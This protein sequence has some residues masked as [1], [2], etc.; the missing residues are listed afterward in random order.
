[1]TWSSH[2]ERR[3]HPWCSVRLSMSAATFGGYC[4]TAMN[5]AG[6]AIAKHSGT[7]RPQVAPNRACS[8]NLLF[9]AP[10]PIPDS[11]LPAD[12]GLP[13]LSADVRNDGNSRQDGHG[14]LSSC[15]V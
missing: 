9:I 8:L 4:L 14:G 1:M 13:P 15:Y 7:N 2:S 11:S 6:W 12:C 3:R 5:E 10:S